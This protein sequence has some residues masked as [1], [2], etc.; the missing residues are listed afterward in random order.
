MSNVVKVELY[1][2]MKDKKSAES[3]KKL[4][5]HAEMLLDLESNPEIKRVF[6][7][8]VCLNPKYNM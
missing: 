1:M 5:H 7:V 4:E 3:M 2:D 8:K 6:G